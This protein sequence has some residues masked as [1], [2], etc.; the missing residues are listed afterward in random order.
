MGLLTS[1][2]EDIDSLLLH[3]VHTQRREWY[4]R[5][6]DGVAVVEDGRGQALLE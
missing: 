6:K 3:S 2:E 4:I 1:C 5:N